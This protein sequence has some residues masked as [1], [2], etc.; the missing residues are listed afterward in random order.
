MIWGT[1]DHIYYELLDGR[2]WAEDGVVVITSP[3]IGVQPLEVSQA[4][5]TADYEGGWIQQVPRVCDIA[6][7]PDDEPPEGWEDHEGGWIQ[8]VPRVGDIA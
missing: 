3:R 5:A 1:P 2:G 7:D 8:Q 4:F 6:W